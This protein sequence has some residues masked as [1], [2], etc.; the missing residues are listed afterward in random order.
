MALVAVS[1]VM[2][3]WLQRPAAPARLEYT[4]LTNFADSATSPALSP[5]GRMLAFIRSE[6]TFGGP[7]QIY[8]KLLPDGEPVQLTHDDLDKRGSPKFSPDGRRLAYAVLKPGS[9]WDTWVVPT[10]GGQPR[11]LLANA[12]GLTWIEAGPRQSRVLFSEL[13]GRSHQ[14]AIVSS[15]ES[16]A[17]HRTVY[18]PP[19]TGMAH[20]SYL[21]PDRKQVLLIEMDRGTWLPCRLA[22]FDG[23]SPG[24][25][26]GPA[27]A[28]C[29]DAAWSPDGKWMYF[30]ADTGNGYHIWRQRFPDGAAEQVT[31]GVTQEEGIE[32]AP[33]G[34]SFV[35][36]IGTSQSTVWFHDS[37]GDRQI[38]SEG[39]GL[40]PSLSADG[41]K[42]YYLL[43][44][45]GAHFATG[46]LWVV[47]L[48]SAQHQQLLSDFLMQHYAISGDG[49]RVAFV[50][51]DHTGRS[52]LWL[53]VLDGRSAPRQ[54]TPDSIKAWKPYFVAGGYV[55]F[56]GD[57]KGTKFVYRVK[58]DGSELQRIVRIDSARSLFSASPD[59]RWVVIP[60]HPSD[61]MES[62]AMIYPVG[63]GT[64]TV[65]CPPCLSDND[66]E[67]TRLPGVSW[68]ADGK[69]M[70]LRFRDS[71]YAIPLRPGQMLPPIPASGFRSK[72]DVA[73]VPGA[74]VILEP[75]AF[76]GANPS[77][78]AFTKVATQRNIYRVPV[79]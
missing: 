21:S 47:D 19:E 59:G 60:G 22:P 10:L 44:P 32:F 64:P 6:Y 71:I 41:K 66:V 17:E 14:M 74:R 56:M 20:R 30:S 25:P 1:T 50:M 72:E 24:K 54:V 55:V 52:P 79:P 18:L 38:T 3:R 65:V 58:E 37:R 4:Q 16:R 11:P 46:E 49:Q 9:V 26:V 8:V 39:W 29:T 40:L 36:S 63:G 51:S 68:S 57:E 76:P 13:T 7:G 77:I 34:R 73:A 12:S 5:D 31:S 69:F 48:E 67:R 62:P 78:Y 45:R 53:A 33:D 28:H 70:Y 75:A 35:T 2:I 61:N 43:R 42:L 15:T 23:S 27:P